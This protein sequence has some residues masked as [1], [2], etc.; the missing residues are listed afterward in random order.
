VQK[1]YAQRMIGVGGIATL[2]FSLILHLA[3]LWDIPPL[4]MALWDGSFLTINMAWA[5]FFGLGLEWLA[6]AL[7]CLLFVEMWAP[8]VR[9]SY[10]LKGTSFGIAW[11]GVMMLVGF[12]LL[13]LLSPLSRNGLAPDPGL[14][15]LG[16]GPATPF[17]FLLAMVGF[18]VIAGLFLDH[19]HI[20][21]P[22]RW[23]LS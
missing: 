20:L 7:L 18:G 9:G 8:H 14:F 19:R 12:P 22:F 21:G 23:P 16:E 5:T 4:N 15:A 10:W 3:M 1:R 13:G 6:G 11:W 17:L 2:V